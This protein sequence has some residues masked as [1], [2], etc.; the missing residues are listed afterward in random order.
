M[1]EINVHSARETNPVI[2]NDARIF[3]LRSKRKIVELSRDNLL[4]T[5]YHF[6]VVDLQ[7][8]LYWLAPHIR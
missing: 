7:R 8:R 6:G 3:V 2:N 4:K 5:K 1:S